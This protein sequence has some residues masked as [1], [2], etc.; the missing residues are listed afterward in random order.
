MEVENMI[1]DFQFNVGDICEDPTG[2]RVKVEDIDMYDYIH[3]SVVD[4]GGEDEMQMGEMSHVAFDHRFV[5]IGSR[6]DRN[7]A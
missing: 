5:R 3:F 4:H 7:A 6:V 1:R 2:L